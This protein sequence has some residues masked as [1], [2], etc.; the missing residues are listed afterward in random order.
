MLMY[1]LYPLWKQENLKSH[2]DL[3]RFLNPHA[4]WEILPGLWEGVLA[5]FKEGP[6]GSSLLITSIL[7]FQILL[8]R[9]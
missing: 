3:V 6:P 4:D 1:L 2:R 7:F 5:V 8:E 9:Q